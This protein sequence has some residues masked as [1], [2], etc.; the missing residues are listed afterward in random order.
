VSGAGSTR[1]FSIGGANTDAVIDN[2]TIANGRAN[3]FTFNEVY[4]PVTL[5]GGIL[6]DGSRLTV[7]AVTFTGNQAIAATDASLAGAG[8]TVDHSTFTHNL[9][10][11]VW[12]P[13]E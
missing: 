6:N 5:G 1:V 12:V 10:T 8:T 11:L 3:D 2:V 7:S 9:A 13:G 4:G